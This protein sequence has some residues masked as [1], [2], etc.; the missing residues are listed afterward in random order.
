MLDRFCPARPEARAAHRPM[1]LMSAP[2]RRRSP[3]ITL[4]LATF[5][6]LFAEPATARATNCNPGTGISPCLDA[7]A[8]WLTPGDARFFSLPRGRVLPA[9]GVGL[10]FAA[11]ALWRP[12][13][14]GVPSPNDTGR[15]VELVERAIEQDTLLAIGLGGHLELGLALPVILRQTGSGSQ[16]LTSQTAAPIESTAARDPRISLAAAF[17]NGGIGIKPQVT[18]ALPFGSTEAY[19][20]AGHVVIAPTL[21][22]SLHHGRFEHALA[23]GARFVPSVDIGSQRIGSQASV[24]LGTSFDI[25]GRELLALCAEGFISQSLA[26]TQSERARLLGV[27]TRL[28]SAEYLVSLRSRPR[29]DEPWTIA[30]GAGSAIAMARQSS[31]A[32][33]ETFVAPPGPGLR[34]VAEVRY[35]PR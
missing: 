28:V 6:W 33:H 29:S 20:S 34:L 22:V 14:L 31:A 8:F 3:L 10:S 13:R 12:L 16:G 17:G 1:M 30:L 11:Q 26:E 9:G 7:N 2:M 15:D 25:L 24:A 19:A 4:G 35:A 5:L 23:L 21:P 32:G 27:K 18:F